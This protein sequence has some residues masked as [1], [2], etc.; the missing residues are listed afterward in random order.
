LNFTALLL[1]LVTFE[2]CAFGLAALTGIRTGY[3]DLHSTAFARLIVHASRCVASNFGRFA[4][5]VVCIAAAV[6]FPFPEAFAAG[7]AHGSSALSAHVD[8]ILAA[9]IIFVK[10]TVCHRTI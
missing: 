1:F 10:G 7:I 3:L 9:A 8:V 6:V 5:D 4:R 2:G